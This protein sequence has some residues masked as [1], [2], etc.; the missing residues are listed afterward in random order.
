MR[1]KCS[2]I[3]AV[4]FAFFCILGCKIFCSYCFGPNNF[5]KLKRELTCTLQQGRKRGEG[6][7]K[8]KEWDE[9]KNDH[10]KFY[11]NLQT[12]TNFECEISIVIEVFPVNFPLALRTLEKVEAL[13]RNSCSSRGINNQFLNRMEKARESGEPQLL[14]CVKR[15]QITAKQLASQKLY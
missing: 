7:T 13:A 10:I 15:Q 3:Q 1:S 2:L 12:T 11:P 14:G 8:N 4:K 5:G 9:Y 6:K